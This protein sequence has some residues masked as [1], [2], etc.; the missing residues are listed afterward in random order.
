MAR[1]EAGLVRVQQVVLGK[2][3]RELIRGSTFNSFGNEMGGVIPVGS[4][5]W[6]RGPEWVS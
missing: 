5:E 3:G 6:W 2:E 1:S 4:S